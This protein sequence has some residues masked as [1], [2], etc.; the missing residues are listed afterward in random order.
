MAGS[1]T[2]HIFQV[3]TG[4]AQIRYHVNRPP[5]PSPSSVVDLLP[6]A[7]ISEMPRVGVTAYLQKVKMP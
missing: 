2:A 5:S 7:R 1:E 6:S 4:P 3:V